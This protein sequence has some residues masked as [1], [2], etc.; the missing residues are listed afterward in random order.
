MTVTHFNLFTLTIA[1]GFVIVKHRPVSPRHLAYSAA[2]AGS[3]MYYITA[4]TS[5]F[6]TMQVSSAIITGTEF[7]HTC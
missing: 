7:A 5:L 4:L 6:I 3:H 2:S 1:V